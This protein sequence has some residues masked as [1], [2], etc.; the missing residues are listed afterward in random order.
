MRNQRSLL[1]PERSI[2]RNVH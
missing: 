2:E 1:I